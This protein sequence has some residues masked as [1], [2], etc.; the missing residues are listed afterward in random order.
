MVREWLRYNYA[1]VIQMPASP[2]PQFESNR[3]C[4]RRTR[5]KSRANHD[6]FKNLTMK[7]ATQ[8][9]DDNPSRVQVKNRL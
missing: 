5:P 2:P 7:A 1:R 4:V 8:E 9:M 6:H 3:T